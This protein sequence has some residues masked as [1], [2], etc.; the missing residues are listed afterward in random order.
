M[1]IAFPKGIA[2]DSYP[3]SGLD[4]DAHSSPN[5]RSTALRVKAIIN[6][7]IENVGLGRADDSNTNAHILYIAIGT[8]GKAVYAVVCDFS[9]G[10]ATVDVDA[11]SL[12]RIPVEVVAHD[13]DSSFEVGMTDFVV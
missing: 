1:N 8:S 6:E 13:L 5:F 4:I 12:K 11:D 7:V 9:M 10:L 2:Q 3:G